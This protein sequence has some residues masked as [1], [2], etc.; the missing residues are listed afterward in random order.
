M[1]N[2]NTSGAPHTGESPTS[3]REAFH[4]CNGSPAAKPHLCTT[5][6]A[7][8]LSE[9]AGLTEWRW[10]MPPQAALTPDMLEAAKLAVDAYFSAQK[11]SWLRP[12][13]D[14]VVQAATNIG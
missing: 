2:E 11:G 5:W 8:L 7:C 12:A 1:A 3:I 10:R 4:K 14:P 9:C 13:Q 6:D